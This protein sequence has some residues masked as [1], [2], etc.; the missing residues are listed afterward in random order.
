MAVSGMQELLANPLLTGHDALARADWEVAR[1]AFHE[2]LRREE[3]P[4]AWEGL[5][6][7]AW[8]L[9]D[10]T[11]CLDARE[12]AYR[13]YRERGDR[14]GAARIAT[15]L[16][17]DYKVFR[18]ERAVANGWLQRA[19]RL[20]EGLDSVPEYGWLMLR[21]A[22]L[23]LFLENDTA[24]ARRLGT[25]AMALGRSLGLIDLEMVGLAVQ[26]FALVNEGELTEGMRLLDEAT[27][28][29]VAG[30][31]TDLSAVGTACCYLIFACERVRD[32]DR[33]AQWCERF[34]EFCKRWRI[35]SFF[36]VCRTHYATVLTWRGELTQAE[37]ELASATAELA[38][39]RPAMVAEGIVRLAELRRRQGRLGEAA[40]LFAQVERH[41]LSRLGRAAL[42]LDQGDT[43]AAADLVDRY[44]RDV[45]VEHRTERAAG[46]ELLVRARA[47]SGTVEE[48]RT[49]LAE[50]QEI[51][52]HVGTEPLRASAS[53]AE[54]LVA[55]AEGDHEGA[56]RRLEDAVD[57]F[58]R[59]GAP[60][61]TAG[62]RLALARSLVALG[63]TAAAEQ[64]IRAAARTLRMMGA[65]ESAA[66]AV[67]LLAEIT[68]PPRERTSRRASA[69]GL[70]EREL[71]VL[72]LVAEGLSNREIGARLF[73]SEHTVHRH[74][75]NIRT[76]LGLPSRAAVVA[77][78]TR[79]GL[80]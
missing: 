7:A 57:L 61:E 17:S 76:R 13:L 71:D 74:L 53:F 80:L 70:T 14:P 69:S 32:L 33:A 72:R 42:L 67:A 38:E 3:T 36:A 39:T 15:Y 23:A 55:A 31:L 10:A 59:S 1:D 28:A 51:A 8:W 5:G 50:L 65:P 6:R 37:A 43:A 63:H 11:T 54:G 60:F 29:A 24:T 62:V 44:L 47:A 77:Y 58:D 30:E 12:R 49:A 25:E 21:D 73:L 19:H 18:G 45:P 78:A 2:A 22:E 40:E 56:R 35:R 27:T 66:R 4:E 46:L 16:S 26:G 52:S 79:Q 68:S 9:D 41:P 75:A 34:K 48:A 20:L 64:E